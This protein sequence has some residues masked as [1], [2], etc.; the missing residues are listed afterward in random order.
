[1]RCAEHKN[2]LCSSIANPNSRAANVASLSRLSSRPGFTYPCCLASLD[3][4]PKEI[5]SGQLFS[6]AL[7]VAANKV[8]MK[9]ACNRGRKPQNRAI[10]QGEGHWA[11][12]PRLLQR[13][14]SSAEL[15]SA[16]LVVWQSQL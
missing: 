12:W 4:L 3:G 2:L 16:L 7:Q 6:G 1:L 11:F 9:G 15:L 10:V 13:P 5:A 8:V 14:L